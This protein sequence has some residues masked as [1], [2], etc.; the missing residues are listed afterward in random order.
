M[1]NNNILWDILRAKISHENA[2]FYQNPRV[3][4][5]PEKKNTMLEIKIN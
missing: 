4:L 5:R 2:K 1:M 3:P